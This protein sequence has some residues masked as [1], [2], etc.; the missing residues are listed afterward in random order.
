MKVNII[1]HFPCPLT[2][3]SLHP[4]PCFAFL[5]ALLSPLLYPTPLSPNLTCPFP[6]LFPPLHLT[7]PPPPPPQVAMDTAGGLQTQRRVL[8]LNMTEG[9]LQIMKGVDESTAQIYF[10]WQIKQ[11]INSRSKERKLGI[12]LEGQGRKDVTFE[13][14]KVCVGV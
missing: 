5:L 14:L 13:T 12:I 8:K 2:F 3:I 9:T 10:Q 4:L 1:I 11:L 6:T 7:H